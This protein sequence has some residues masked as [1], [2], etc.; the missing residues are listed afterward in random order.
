MFDVESLESEPLTKKPKLEPPDYPDIKPKLKTADPNWE[1]PSDIE[2]STSYICTYQYH[3]DLEH[4]EM[5]FNSLR[6]PKHF[7]LRI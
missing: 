3:R 6:H 2:V 1:L 4:S 5:K 7:T